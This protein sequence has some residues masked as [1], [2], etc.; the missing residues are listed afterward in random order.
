MHTGVPP[1]SSGGTY[2]NEVAPG[3]EE[4]CANY[5]YGNFRAHF[6]HI[7]W[8]KVKDEVD[9]SRPFVIHMQQPGGYGNHSVTGRGYSDYDED[10]VFIQDT[11]D[12]NTHT[13][14]YGNWYWADMT[15]VVQ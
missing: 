4:V 9:E 3:I 1:R 14:A 10:Y 6:E 2:D 11:W 8:D 13:I 5:G 12:E 7:S 15:W